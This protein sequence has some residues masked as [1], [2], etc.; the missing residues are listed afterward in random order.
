[1]VGDLKSVLGSMAGPCKDLP[2]G[3]ECDLGVTG[4]VA[5]L[6]GDANPGVDILV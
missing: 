5:G 2:S 6:V 1:M 3:E 4:G